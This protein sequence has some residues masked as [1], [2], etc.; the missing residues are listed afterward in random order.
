MHHDAHGVFPSNGG[1]D[2]RQV[3]ET[4]SGGH[5]EV[6]T[7]TNDDGVV[8]HWGVGDPTRPPET[9]TG[10]WAYAILPYIE[11]G[12]LYR[13]VD[14]ET[15]LSL[16]HC[17]SRRVP[18]PQVPVDD[19]DASYSGGGW[20]WGKINYSANGRFLKNRPGY[21]HPADDRTS[22]PNGTRQPIGLARMADITDGA[23]ST[24]LTGEKAMDPNNADT[25]GWFWTSRSSW[26]ARMPR[27]V[28]APA[29]CRIA[30]ESHSR[31]TGGRL[32]PRGHSSVSPTARCDSSASARTP[33]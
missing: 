26:E 17:P 29:S 12:N 4:V 2:G 16:Y 24:I 11:Q 21:R 20:A 9:Q 27:R 3:I 32:I 8:Y 28:G 18:R 30:R 14:F 15:S 13:D 25:G 7:R 1:W 33:R 19:D 10:G 5:A 31:T 6:Y 22:V 23:S